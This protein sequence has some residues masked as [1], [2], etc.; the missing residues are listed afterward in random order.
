M[1]TIPMTR[2]GKDH[3][4]TFAYIDTIAVDNPRNDGLISPDNKRMRTNLSTHPGL[5]VSIMGTFHDGAKYPTRLNDGEI[6]N[7]DDWDCLSD[8]VAEKLLQEYGTG[9]QPLYKFTEL[10]RDI[11]HQLRDHKASGGTFHNFTPTDTRAL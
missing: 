8:M 9:L 7:H 10:G 4:S 2:W 1:N 11:I 5:A 3:W 6:E